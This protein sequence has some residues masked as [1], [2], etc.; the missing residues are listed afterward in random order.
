MRVHRALDQIIPTTRAENAVAES[1]IGGVRD[2]TGSRGEGGR[3]QPAC[4]APTQDLGDPCL[5]QRIAQS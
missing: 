5:G 2:L 4:V 1:Q 3:L